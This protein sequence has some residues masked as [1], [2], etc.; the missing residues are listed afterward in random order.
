MDEKEIVERLGPKEAHAVCNAIF[1]TVRSLRA[2][3]GGAPVD[4]KARLAQWG[5]AIK[6]CMGSG[7]ID[8]SAGDFLLSDLSDRT[9]QAIIRIRNTHPSKVKVW[10]L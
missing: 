3:T 2:T 7:K 10:L 5:V 8:W 6:Y 1:N 9:V 4:K